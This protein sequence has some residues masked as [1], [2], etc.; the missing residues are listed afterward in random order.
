MCAAAAGDA[1]VIRAQVSVFTRYFYAATHI[2]D[3]RVV[4]G[5]RIAVVAR[6]AEVD[7]HAAD[8]VLTRVSG[9]GDPIVATARRAGAQSERACVVFGACG[10]VVALE[11]ITGLD[12]ANVWIT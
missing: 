6:A 1:G 5:A 7:M 11:E 9:A 2:G 8:F 3:A 4:T 12:A 10:A